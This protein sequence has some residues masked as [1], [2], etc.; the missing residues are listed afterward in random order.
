MRR[1]WEQQGGAKMAPSLLQSV[2]YVAHGEEMATSTEDYRG[3]RVL[4]D[5]PGLSSADSFIS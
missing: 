4:R 5:Q 2:L 1:I 3:D